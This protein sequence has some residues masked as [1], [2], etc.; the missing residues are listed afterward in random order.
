MKWLGVACQYDP[1]V[2]RIENE[3]AILSPPGMTVVTACCMTDC[4]NIHA[5]L[6][7]LFDSLFLEQTSL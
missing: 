5:E 2:N 7:G 6:Y 4:Y 3:Y 1:L